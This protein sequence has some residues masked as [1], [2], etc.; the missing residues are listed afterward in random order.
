MPGH[1][2][3]KEF[4]RRNLSLDLEFGGINPRGPCS[5]YYLGPVDDG[6]W[7]NIVGRRADGSMEPKAALGRRAPAGQQSQEGPV[8]S[9]TVARWPQI[10]GKWLCGVSC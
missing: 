2:L 9:L 7:K 4:I 10:A 5:C 8:C 3:F 6:V 1:L